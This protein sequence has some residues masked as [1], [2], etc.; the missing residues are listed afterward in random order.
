MVEEVTVPNVTPTTIYTT[1]Y[2]YVY[3]AYGN[4]TS[5]TVTQTEE[6]GDQIN[7]LQQKSWTAYTNDGNY[8]V[9]TTN[10]Y[11]ETTYYEY[12]DDT[13]VLKWVK[14]PG[15]TDATRTNYSYDDMYRLIGTSAAPDQNTQMS[16]TYT[17]HKDLLA[18]ITTGSNTTYTITYGDYNLRKS[19][20][21]GS[22]VLATYHY[23]NE[24]PYA[25]ENE[26]RNHNLERL[27]Y[28]NGDS[29]KYTY[30]YLGRVTSAKYQEDGSASVSRV[31]NY[32]YDNTG[33]LAYM[34][35]SATG[36]ETRCS[37]DKTSR[38]AMV[39]ETDN[40]TFYHVFLYFYDDKGNII[41]A[42]E[43][44]RFADDKD[45]TGQGNTV[46]YEYLNQYQYL[47]DYKN[48]LA[49]VL[50]SKTQKDYAYDGFDRL[51]EETVVH[52][53][54]NTSTPILSNRYTYED[55]TVIESGTVSEYTGSR[56]SE[57]ET[58]FDGVTKVYSYTYDDNGNITSISDGAHTTRYFY[59]AANQLIREENEAAGKIWVWTYDN[60]GNI[61]S[62]K[63]YAYTTETLGAPTNTANYVYGDAS[64]GD[65]LTSYSGQGFTYDNGG[66][67]ISDGTWA[68]TWRQGRQLAS[69][70]KGSETWT[71]EYDANGMRT[72][73][74]CGDKVYTYVYSGS[75]LTAMTC[76]WDK[77]L[78]TYDAAGKPLTLEYHD[79]FYCQAH[80]G[81][82]CGSNCE[83]YY[84]VTNLQGDVIALLDSS[85]NVKAEYAYDA[86]GNHV[87]TPSSF[88]GNYNP[89][90]YRGYV[91]DRETGLYYLQNGYYD[92]LIGRWIQPVKGSTYN[93][94]GNTGV[95]LYSY[96]NNNPISIAY[97]SASVSGK[98][99]SRTLSSTGLDIGS[100]ISNTEINIQSN[101]YPD[102]S[103]L[104][105]G[106]SFLENGFS[107]ITGVIDGYR[108]IKNLDSIAGLEKAS[109]ALL[110]VGI[111]LNVGLS[112]YENFA[113]NQ[114][115]DISQRIDNFLGDVAYIA[116]S[117]AATY[118]VGYLVAMIPY[119]GPVLAVPASMLTGTILEQMWSGEDILWIEGF[120]ININGQSLDEWVG[121]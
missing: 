89:L 119:V 108:Q 106:F 80:N 99:G 55:I 76:S 48:R 56:V 24:N 63:E 5:I 62:K 102:L 12:D 13:G 68:Y 117:S 61:L 91:Y 32:V 69:M 94:S 118:G 33:A 104:S 9:S 51:T 34:T 84:Y 28:G 105:S 97:C 64:W 44:I 96:A 4:V 112:A 22:R 15:D 10:T 88:I 85:G 21:V 114:S 95:N 16:A 111:A 115:Q 19:V 7:T 98:A 107:M 11:N 103:F 110:F 77:F 45:S 18:T 78:F 116:I 58:E 49:S 14:Y 92:P 2:G 43:C 1:T 53:E 101:N 65:L 46:L 120:K 36:I 79:T 86:W 121:G 113:V 83:I 100:H 35:D 81:G 57:V 50:T 75:Q 38:A 37:Y 27:D 52:V 20:Q 26:K 23:S 17:Y 71:F 41:G 90:R 70:I 47:Y 74:A 82:A 8:I 93:S 39:E 30:D 29:V 40:E 31:I 72:K 25:S 6:I 54:G 42:Q 67:L 3:D 87:E 73:R 59:D 66:N 60:A 109:N